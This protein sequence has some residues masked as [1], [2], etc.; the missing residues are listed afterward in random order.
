[1]TRETLMGT[2][3]TALRLLAGAT[4]ALAVALLAVH[5]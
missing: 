1:V 3:E 5:L 2:Q 4:V